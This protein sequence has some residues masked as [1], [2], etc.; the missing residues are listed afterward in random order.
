MTSGGGSRI[1]GG[2][3]GARSAGGAGGPRITGEAEIISILAPLSARF[4]GAFALLDD[5]AV[6]TPE[7]GHDVVL[8]TDAVAEGVHFLATDRPEAIAWKALAVNVSDLI[9]KGA[10]PRVYLLSLAFPAPP[11]RSWVEAF[12]AGLAAAQA[13]FGVVLAGGDTDRRAGPLSVTV[14][15]AGEVP[16]GRMV[17]RGAAEAGDLLYV[18][19]TLGDAA[20]GLAMAQDDSLAARWGLTRE[21]A[22]HLIGR[23]RRPHPPLPLVEVLR[24]YVRAAMDLSDG[25]VKDLG[26]M[27]RASGCGAEVEV[28]RVPQSAAAKAVVS[29]HPEM[30]GRI[31]SGGDD[32]E[33]LAAV[34]PGAVADFERA[35]AACGVPVSHIGRCVET[36]GVTV[37]DRSG[38][39]VD[40]AG[41]GWDHF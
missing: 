11:E 16:T 3:G 35:A 38:A 31:L 41:S 24:M 2:T 18:S 27:V 26:R 14:A 32:Y 4:P 22:A 10:R 36:A 21:S 29:R 9:A 33:V 30:A 5:C 25:L 17:R 20:L 13:H 7:P 6:W 39:P 1:A 37:R 19:G 8:N 40:I 34:P 15:A 23:Y 28:E 12:A